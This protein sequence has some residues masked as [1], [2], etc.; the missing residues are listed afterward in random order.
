VIRH[1]SRGQWLLRATVAVGPVV[2]LLATI[3]A[4]ATPRWWLVVLVAGVSAGFAI[5]PESAAG[6][7]A[8]VLVILWWGLGLRETLH[9]AVVVAAAALLA[10]HLAATVAAYGP[11]TLAVEPAVVRLWAVRGVLVFPAAVLAWVAVRLLDEQPEQAGVWAAGLAG[12]LVT[13][14]AANVLY[15]RRPG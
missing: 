7:G 8:Y 5:L 14:V 6:T 3:P 15:V 1:W 10:S 4:G 11:S 13:M 2:A 9:P 12:L